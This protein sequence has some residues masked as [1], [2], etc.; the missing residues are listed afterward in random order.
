[1]YQASAKNWVTPN[2]SHIYSY[3][4]Q[5]SKKSA[6][7][8]TIHP[9]NLICRFI[10]NW[11]SLT[12]TAI[13]PFYKL[14]GANPPWEARIFLT[15]T[16]IPS[17]F[18]NPNY[19]CVCAES[20]YLRIGIPNGVLPSDFPSTAQHYFRSIPCVPLDGTLCS[21]CFVL[22]GDTWPHSVF[23]PN[24]RAGILILATLL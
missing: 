10:K 8:F 24:K 19:T 17:I 2:F 14:H 16:E 5:V 4:S 9:I 12:C 18:L 13:V 23:G 3:R 6:T 20:D 15:N 7:F 1:M 22:P 11:I 21:S